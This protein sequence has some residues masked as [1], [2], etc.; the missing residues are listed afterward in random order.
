MKG[1]NLL[2]RFSRP[3]TII[4][5][6]VSIAVLG[7]MAAGLSV[8]HSIHFW[9]AL[10]SGLACNIFITGFNQVVDV[11]LD[12]RNKPDL[13]L[14]SGELSMR[15]GK[16]IVATSLLISL[17]TAAA[18]GWRFLALVAV[19]A[20]LG[21]VYSWK[22]VFLKKRHATA[23]MAITL[24]RGVLINFGFYAYF[25]GAWVG[26]FPSELWLLAVFVSLFSLG[27]AWFKDIPDLAGDAE[28]EI[29]TLAVRLGA[30]KVFRLGVFT[31]ATAYVI[32]ALWPWIVGI[33][34]ASPVVIGVGHAVLGGA[35][36]A[37]AAK[38]SPERMPSMQRFY[39]VFWVLFFLEYILFAAAFMLS[40]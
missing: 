34:L 5:S 36:L 1:L 23:A 24:V 22:Q 16:S 17:G 12:Q 6:A 13:P 33:G 39:K 28:F 9:L 20:I 15:V 19:I 26:P 14:A 27:I 25:S 30:L 21:F 32:G 37:F 4:G 10:G 18:L 7:L 2:W 29:G 35:F 3:H 31:I 38:T 40:S 8:Y 11:A